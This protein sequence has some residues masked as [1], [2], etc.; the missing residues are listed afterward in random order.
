MTPVAT[1]KSAKL[2]ACNAQR[3]GDAAD[4]VDARAGHESRAAADPP[5]HSDT[6]IVASADP[7]TYVVT[8]SVASVFVCASENPTSPFIEINADAVDQQQR[9]AA[10]EQEDVAAG[11]LHEGHASVAMIATAAAGKVRMIRC[12]R[13]LS[14]EPSRASQ[15]QFAASPCRA[16][17]RLMPLAPLA[18]EI[19]E[20]WFGPRPG[21]V[22]S[23]AAEPIRGARHATRSVWFRKD[24][25]FDAEIRG[26][27]GAALDAGAR[28]RVRR[29]VHDGARLACARRAARP[30]H[31]QCVSRFA[32]RV[33]RRSPA[34]SPPRSMR[35][36]AD[37]RSRP[38][39]PTNAGS[40]TCRSST[41]VAGDAGSLARA[42]R[43]RSRPR[44][45]TTRRCNGR[46]G[47]RK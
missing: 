9:L 23:G 2:P 8:P 41:R 36:S 18:A 11:R 30:V 13:P 25:A 34:R 32:G 20:F 5:I 45:G 38:R 31:A 44:H 7:S 22:A 43:R 46:N 24:A 40:C 6:G 14:I 42:V 17:R 35:S 21:E 12:T 10:G 29:V 15:D 26:R 39:S 3:S 27:F 47:T 37:L 4:D 1:Q 33:R 19:L 16:S 28:R